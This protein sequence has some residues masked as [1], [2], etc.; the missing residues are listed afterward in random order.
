MERIFYDKDGNEL[1]FKLVKPFNNGIYGEAYRV[2]EDE[3]VKLF[4]ESEPGDEVIDDVEAF[5]I[6]MSL[7]LP[8]FYKVYK[9]LYSYIKCIEGY[10]GKYYQIEPLNIFEMP[11]DYLLDNFNGI[12]ETMKEITKNK[13]NMCDLHGKNFF[14]TKDSIIISDADFYYHDPSIYLLNENKK[15]LY[16]AFCELL[17]NMFYGFYKRNL[18]RKEYRECVKSIY[19]LF[20]V[21]NSPEILNSKLRSYKKPIDYLHSQVSK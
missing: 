14:L 10:L 4:I 12:Y 17:V 6:L 7:D 21:D 5:E 3:V 16:N 18:P 15:R 9:L 1:F 2:S 11:I 19:S 8:N 13:I 20:D